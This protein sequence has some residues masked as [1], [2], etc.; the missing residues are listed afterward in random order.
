[1]KK[2]KFKFNRSY[3]AVVFIALVLL[4]IT[5]FNNGS[6]KKLLSLNTQIPA[7]QPAAV[8]ASLADKE[9]TLTSDANS[10][11]IIEATIPSGQTV[12]KVVTLDSLSNVAFFAGWQGEGLSVSLVD[13]KNQVIDLTKN[14]I[15]DQKFILG[16]NEA[17]PLY[18]KTKDGASLSY[19]I[20][21]IAF[22]GLWKFR[23]KNTGTKAINFGTMISGTSNINF[24]ILSNDRLMNQE[25]FFPEIYAAE[26]SP[27]T[28]KLTPLKGLSIKLEVFED[29][30]PKTKDKALPIHTV[31]LS[32]Q[33][34]K[35]TN[36]GYY[37]Y[38]YVKNLKSGDYRTFYTISGKNL[39][40][41]S[42]KRY[43]GT[44]DGYLTVSNGHA[45]IAGNFQ[46][47][48][49]DVD[50][51][52]LADY[53][54][55]SFWLNVTKPGNYSVVGY[56]TGPNGNVLHEAN[57]L[58]IKNTGVTAPNFLFNLASSNNVD[59]VYKLK[60]LIVFEETETVGSGWVDTWRGDSYTTQ[61]YKVTK[62]RIK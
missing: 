53:I 23:L 7:Q 47:K 32:D 20:N 61:N 14:V 4:V 2:K 16:K 49:V 58:E 26:Y 31:Y 5:L 24:S 36:D 9:M 10:I 54:N 48:S 1:M 34:S 37:G 45:Q 18:F 15:S 42:F 40:G 6:F 50:G 13:P 29:K 22:P 57:R 56:L 41:Q 44:S 33:Q 62:K 59:G 27:T 39:A 51:D 19:K 38:Q 35:L 46:D 17:N 52:K 43:L 60:D 8:L 11:E 25:W 55:L 12:E 3:L 30:W 21:T 28:K